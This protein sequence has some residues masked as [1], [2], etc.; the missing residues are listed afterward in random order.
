MSDLRAG[1]RE[2]GDEDYAVA[3]A[4]AW[5]SGAALEM[6]F[7]DGAESFGEACQRMA[8][9][10]LKGLGQQAV[11]RQLGHTSHRVTEEHY[12]EAGTVERARGRA[13]M[14]VLSGGGG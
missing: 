5:A 3:I 4:D 10:T 12:L 1:A 13:V 8:A 9:E 11:A 6:A 2:I 14:Q 7:A